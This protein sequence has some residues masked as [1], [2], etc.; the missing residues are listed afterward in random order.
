MARRKLSS[1]INVV[2]YIDV[3]LVLLIIFMITAP[4][5]TQGIDIDL[6]DANAASISSTEQDWKVSV[7][8]KGQVGVHANG[9]NDEALTDE[10]LTA[11]IKTLLATQ[12][13]HMI[14]VE[15]DSAVRYERVAQ[16]LAVLQEAGAKKIGF[17]TQPVGEEKKKP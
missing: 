3:M 9:E 13:D 8:E 11:R 1:D 14:L 5:L 10:Q 7:N 17:I 4:L 15:G 6:P 16:T 2:P 12:P